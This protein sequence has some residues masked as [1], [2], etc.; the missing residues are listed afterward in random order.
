MRLDE[1]VTPS[2]EDAHVSDGSSNA[3]PLSRPALAA[4]PPILVTTGRLLPI[5]ER[6]QFHLLVDRDC[7]ARGEREE[8]RKLSRTA[9]LVFSTRSRSGV[10]QRRSV[11][12]QRTVSALLSAVAGG[13]CTEDEGIPG[14]DEVDEVE[15]GDAIK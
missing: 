6:E 10:R 14:V 1:F 5:T 9:V 15:M 4:L 11:E 13:E 3:A 7:E 8:R 2:C 12:S